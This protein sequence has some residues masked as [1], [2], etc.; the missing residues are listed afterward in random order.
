MKINKLIKRIAGTSLIVGIVSFVPNV[1]NAYDLQFTPVVH[2]E[3][4][5]RINN[6][7]ATYDE[8]I[9]EGDDLL[10]IGEADE[11]II[12]YTEAIK[13]EPKN[14]VAYNKRG[15]AYYSMKSYSDAADD[16]NKAV[17]LAPDDPVAYLNR[18][19]IYGLLNDRNQNA[20]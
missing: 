1:P 15:L 6:A 20:R 4:V 8:K 18:G 17:T 10:Y 12:L 16:F 19:Y 11:A 5:V 3:R 14:F 2:A 7:K 13:M 9:E